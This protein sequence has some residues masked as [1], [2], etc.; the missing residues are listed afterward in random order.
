[1]TTVFVQFTL[2][3]WLSFSCCR[4]SFCKTCN[5][6]LWLNDLF[7]RC[8]SFRL[9]ILFFSCRLFDSGCSFSL[10][11]NYGLRLNDRIRNVFYRG[12]SY[13]LAHLPDRGKPAAKDTSL[14]LDML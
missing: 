7:F 6:W 9:L 13:L 11:V 10:R 2:V 1:M 4:G 8:A 12:I 5:C 14:R 3:C